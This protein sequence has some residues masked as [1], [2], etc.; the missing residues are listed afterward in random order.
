MRSG[1]GTFE[2]ASTDWVVES[3]SGGD[4]G[5]TGRTDTR[6]LVTGIVVSPLLRRPE[7]VIYSP[8]LP[9]ASNADHQLPEAE[10]A[11]D[12]RV[13]RRWSHG[14]PTRR[15]PARC[16]V[17]IGPSSWGDR[18]QVTDGDGR[19][20]RSLDFAGR[21]RRRSRCHGRGSTDDW[22]ARRT[23]CETLR[24]SRPDW[25]LLFGGLLVARRSLVIVVQSSAPSPWR[26]TPAGL[27]AQVEP[28]GALLST[29]RCCSP[30]RALGL[31]HRRTAPSF[32]ASARV[33]SAARRGPAARMARSAAHHRRRH[34]V[35]ARWRGPS[36]APPWPEHV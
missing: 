14:L 15:S 13:P 17:D 19:Q 21:S 26:R 22:P 4:V 32:L 27:A 25:A 7:R 31:I 2:S 8:V 1:P 16:R 29:S 12:R 5:R 23:D 10:S 3:F 11:R 20:R 34:A 24:W 33:F 9:A 36:R 6:L 35:A 28:I 30:D 18:Q